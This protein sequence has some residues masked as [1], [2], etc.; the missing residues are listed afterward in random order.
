V[1]DSQR[2]EEATDRP[3]TPL[4]AA[5]WSIGL[6]LL[7]SCAVQ[8]TEAVRPGA[9]SD[10]VNLGACTV[11]AT[12]IVVFAMMRVHARDASLRA[13]LGV[14]PVAP[15]HLALAIA[16]GAGLH[17][18]LSTIDDRIVERWPFG[19][20]DAAAME[21]LLRVTTASSRVALVVAA[22]VAMPLARELFF[23]GILFGEL[24]RATSARVAMVGSAVF[25]ACSS[26][27]WRMM[28]TALVLGL[29]LVRLR[30][31]SGTVLSAAVAHVAYW[32]VEGVPILRGRDPGA[33]VVYPTRWIVGG[34]VFALLA[35]VAVGAGKREDE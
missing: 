4:A 7:E 21:K 12:S 31:Q 6:G 23:R 22:F 27:D 3:L 19:A 33:S 9:L 34:A 2:P 26:L 17:P 20:D 1:S 35:L 15:L 11:L 18:L 28:P 30:E 5:G 10:V 29:A 16:A 32:A 8:A 24:R 25:Y 14:R 13:T